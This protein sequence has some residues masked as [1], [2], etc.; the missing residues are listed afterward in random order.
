MLEPLFHQQP[1]HPGLAHYIIHTYDYP[2]LAPLGLNAARAYAKIAPSV[3]HALHMPSHIFIRLGLWEEAARSNEASAKAGREYEVKT[4]MPAGEAWDQR[5]HALDYLEYAY[6]QLGQIDKAKL[7][8]DDISA[9]RS[10][11]PNNITAS[12]A[13][14]AVPARFFLEQG[15]WNDAANLSVVTDS[16]ESQAITHWARAVGAARSGKIAEAKQDLETLK[17]LRDKLQ[18]SPGPYPW[19]QIVEVQ[20]LQAAAWIAHATGNNDEALAQMRAAADLEAQTD[21]HPATPGA[22]LPAREQLAD[23]LMETGRPADAVKEYEAA[24][25]ETPKRRHSMEVLESRRVA[26]N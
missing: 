7:V 22:V 18:Q 23:L 25:R 11:H 24:L 9:L 17:T 19:H 1:K 8:L 5:L 15:K 6:L 3:P 4:K 14:S 16:P 12:Y 10:A 2:E 21:K 20:R 13:R 26:T